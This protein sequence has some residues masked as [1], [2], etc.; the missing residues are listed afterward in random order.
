MPTQ[1]AL[2][3]GSGQSKILGLIPLVPT[4]DTPEAQK[5]L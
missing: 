1:L 5:N 2:L 4:K 3:H